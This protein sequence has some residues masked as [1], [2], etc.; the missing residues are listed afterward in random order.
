MFLRIW[1]AVM[2]LL[3]SALWRRDERGQTTAEYALVLVGAAAVAL[4]LLTWATGSGRI[5]WLLD[6]MVDTVAN[7][8]K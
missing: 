4:L 5:G 8:V 6:K 3:V 1:T 2:T 7:M